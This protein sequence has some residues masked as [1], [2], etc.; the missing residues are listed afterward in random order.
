VN[1]SI[2]SAVGACTSTN[3]W[4]TVTSHAPP[5]TASVPDVKRTPEMARSRCSCVGPSA[6][7]SWPLPLSILGRPFSS[8][9]GTLV[10]ELSDTSTSCSVSGQSAGA[11]TAHTKCRFAFTRRAPFR[12][13]WNSWSGAEPLPTTNASVTFE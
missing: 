11:A 10:T 9:N 12:L 8:T 2:G 5:A 6:T 13:R 3:A 1:S 4:S 7:T